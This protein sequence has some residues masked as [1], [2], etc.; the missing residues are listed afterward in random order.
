M[1]QPRRSGLIKP[2]Y[3]DGALLTPEYVPVAGE[4]GRLVDGIPLADLQVRAYSLKSQINRKPQADEDLIW[5]AV[6]YDVEF[7][8]DLV[9]SHFK[10]KDAATAETVFVIAKD[11]TP[12]GSATFAAAATDATFTFTAD[13]DFDE[14]EYF[15]FTAPSSPDAT[16]GRLSLTVKGRRKSSAE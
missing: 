10:A 7:P 13:V 3:D 15:S 9:G 14:G 4:G 1:T 8:E 6:E 12:I 11:G 5:T 16:L 2:V